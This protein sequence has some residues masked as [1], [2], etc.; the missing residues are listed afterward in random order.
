MPAE[1]TTVRVH[2]HW[3][4][5]GFDARLFDVAHLREAGL[6]TGA[7][8]GGRGAT[9]FFTWRDRDLVLRHYRRGGLVRHVSTADYLWLG[10]ER[11]RA[12]AEFE[13]LRHAERRA[14]P[15]PRVVAASVTRRPLRYRA[16][17]ITERVPGDTWWARLGSEQHRSPWPAI[18]CCI[19]AFHAAGI[20]HA[21]LN[22]HNILIGSTAA[23]DETTGVHL[24]DFDRARYRTSTASTATRWQSGNLQR[25]RRSIRKRLAAGWTDDHQR[26]WA[27]LDAAWRANLEQRSAD[28]RDGTTG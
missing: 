1:S 19:A 8:S 6:L 24:I 21:D 11:T 27:A 3:R 9:W 10:L 7:A 2:P 12:M 18:G 23:A 25:L 17:L 16:A 20:D 5:A 28:G 4:D 22:A 26:G 15:A 14:L 13:V